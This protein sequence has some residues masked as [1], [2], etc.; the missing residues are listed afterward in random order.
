MIEALPRLLAQ[1]PL[2]PHFQVPSGNEIVEGFWLKLTPM[3]V[4]PT[5][6]G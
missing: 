6:I 5:L 3:A 4:L 1:E 2:E